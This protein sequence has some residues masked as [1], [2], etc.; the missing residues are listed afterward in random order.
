MNYY[1]LKKDINHN[2][3]LF[4][5]VSTRFSDLRSPTPAPPVKFSPQVETKVTDEYI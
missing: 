4:V 3:L 2:L 1:Y 5:T